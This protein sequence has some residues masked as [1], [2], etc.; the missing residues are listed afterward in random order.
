MEKK[1]AAI[2]SWP[3]TTDTKWITESF[4]VL[5]FSENPLAMPNSVQELV[6]LTDPFGTVR[7]SLLR[8]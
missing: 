2:V 7:P 8:N 3:D 6:T 1:P 4:R 5:F